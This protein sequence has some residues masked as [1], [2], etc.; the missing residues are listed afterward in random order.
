M[1]IEESKIVLSLKKYY[2]YF[3]GEMKVIGSRTI[4]SFERNEKKENQKNLFCIEVEH[5]DEEAAMVHG[6]SFNFELLDQAYE[7]VFNV[8]AE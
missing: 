1:G 7:L 2:K 5:I 4:I 3:T 6:E 8:E